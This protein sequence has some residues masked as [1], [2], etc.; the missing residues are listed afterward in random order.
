[1]EARR[2]LHEEI[3]NAEV[4]LV[5]V[6]DSRDLG[7]Q[8]AAPT[9]FELRSNTQAPEGPGAPG[10]WAHLELPGQSHSL[11][12]ILWHGLWCPFEGDLQSIVMKFPTSGVQRELLF[13]VRA[14][15]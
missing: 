9:W 13:A 10:T 5:P 7:H 1:M 14:H 11:R 8:P 15:L 3:D 12:N 2:A 6:R 4:N